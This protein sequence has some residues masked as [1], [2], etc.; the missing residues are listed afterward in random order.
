[1]LYQQYGTTGIEVS[2]IGFGG[3]RFEDQNNVDACAELVKAAYDAGINYFDTAPGYG[4]S[5]DLF[6]VAFK[7]MLKTR[8]ER[9][10]YVSTK[11]MAREPAKA[12][13]DLE[14]SLE[15]MGLEYI[16]FYHFWCVLTMDDYLG[17]KKNGILNELEKFKDEGLIRH[18][19][20]S[21]HMTGSDI[22]TMLNDYPFEGVLLGYSAANFAYR[23]QGIE[24]AS[25][26]DRGVVV[27]NPL[28]GGVIPQHPERFEFVKTRPD[29][30]VAEA[31]LR[32]LINDPRITIALNGL[33]NLQQL[34][35]AISAVDGFEP[36]GEAQ[37]K[38]I[39]SQ[40]KDSFDELCTACQ[41][42]D[43]CPKGIPIPKFMDVYNH[44]LFSNSVKDMVN[45]MRY[46]WGIN[47]EDGYL[48]KCT[49]CGKCEQACTQHL[50]IIKRLKFIR[51]EAEKF[52][53]A[54]QAEKAAVKEQE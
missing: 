11:T 45:R 29:E 1:M 30:T 12:R 39:R 20:V 43:K 42:C 8:S 15:R 46:H 33:A 53:K 24:A 47:L 22:E 38:R 25:K 2:V 7:E 5:E 3:M 48:E 36:I 49:E 27:M 34:E 9:P 28:N 51:E 26:L 16:D 6:G 19:A 54:E 18:I 31:A 44:Y 14:K 41:Y 40:I 17:R 23:E 10:F 50:P 13:A 21:S 32:F 4:K 35:E 37:I 52:I